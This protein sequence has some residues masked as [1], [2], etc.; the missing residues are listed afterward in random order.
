MHRPPKYIQ[1][2]VPASHILSGLSSRHTNTNITQP[3]Y[4][5][6]PDLWAIILLDG[7]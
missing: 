7:L 2:T 1:S 6:A 4:S 5:S 3:C